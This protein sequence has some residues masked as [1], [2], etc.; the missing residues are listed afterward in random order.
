MKPPYNLFN[1]LKQTNKQ[2]G[3]VKR[4]FLL[5]DSNYYDLKTFLKKCSLKTMRPKL[6]QIFS[7]PVL[8]KE[9]V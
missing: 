4:L 2:K 3:D 7:V 8:G 9:K 1:Y 6:K 5:L